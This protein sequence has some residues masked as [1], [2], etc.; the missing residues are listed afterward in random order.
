MWLIFRERFK[1][2]PDR[3]ALIDLR[4]FFH[5]LTKRAGLAA[6][7]SSFTI[8]CAA[9][10]AG[11]S[12]SFGAEQLPLVTEKRHDVGNH[13]VVIV[14]KFVQADVEFYPPVRCASD[15]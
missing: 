13:A 6:T 5:S 9:S 7:H 1:V 12:H 10:C 11:G 14:G 2:G 4:R 15:T 8:S 3:P